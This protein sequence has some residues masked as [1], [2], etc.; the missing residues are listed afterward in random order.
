MGLDQYLHADIY[1]SRNDWTAEDLQESQTFKNLVEHLNITHY[2]QSGFAGISVEVPM[3]YWRKCNQIHHWFV[4]N[5]QDGEDNCGKYFVS[6]EHLTELLDLCKQV[7]ADHSLADELL[8]S[9][10]GFFFGST[11]Y[12][13][14]YFQ[15][16]K[17][18]VETINNC[19]AS[20]YEYFSYS[21]SW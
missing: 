6:R 11:D 21:S 14:W 1:V 8:P 3:G 19:L 15:D 16:L 17:H 20:P 10:A 13:E 5:V 18:T 2:D 4:D 12:D 7:L 9:Q